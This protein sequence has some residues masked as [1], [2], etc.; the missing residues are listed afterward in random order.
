MTRSSSD[1]SLGLL[2]KLRGQEVDALEL[3]M[4]RKAQL[5]QRYRNTIHALTELC[6]R[7]QP[8]AAHPALAINAGQ[9]KGALLSVLEDQKRDLALHE[10]DMAADR[11]ILLA[12]YRKQVGLEQ[13]IDQRRR[14]EHL[15][16]S[17]R[18]QK[19]TDDLAAQRSSTRRV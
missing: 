1:D 10:M 5:E 2:A 15:E 7:P 8:I 6:Q 16:R 3:K 13:V 4:R 19:R 12:A 18:E 11:Q 14:Q 17:R 9:Y